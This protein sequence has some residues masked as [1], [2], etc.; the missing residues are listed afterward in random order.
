MKYILADTYINDY[1]GLTREQKD[2][3]K[4]SLPNFKKAIE[5]RNASLRRKLNLHPLGHVGPP[6]IWGGH[7]INRK[8]DFV[9]TYNHD[10]YDGEPAILIRRIGDHSVYKNP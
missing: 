7:L 3:V 1:S 8:S 4:N 5:E 2:I 9:F 10:T 6:I